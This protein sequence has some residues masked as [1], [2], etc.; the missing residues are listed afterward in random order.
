MLLFYCPA[1]PKK[2]LQ[3]YPTS[4]PHVPYSQQ[5]HRNNLVFLNFGGAN[6]REKQVGSC[7]RHNVSIKHFGASKSVQVVFFHFLN[8]TDGH[9]PESSKKES[10]TFCTFRIKIKKHNAANYE[11]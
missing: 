2:P 4:S 9:A 5:S 10:V 8:N 1:S 11:N 3:K 6:I 7:Y